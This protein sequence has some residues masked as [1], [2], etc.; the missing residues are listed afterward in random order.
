MYTLKGFG[1]TLLSYDVLDV[2]LYKSV[3]FQNHQPSYSII[4]LGLV[5]FHLLFSSTTYNMEANNFYF[6]KIDKN[7]AKQKKCYSH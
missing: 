2:F 5:L 4:I 3:S 6:R 1:W 7:Q